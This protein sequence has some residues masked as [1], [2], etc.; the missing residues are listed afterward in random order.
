MAMTVGKPGGDSE[1]MMDINTTPLIDVMLVLLV[2]LIITLPVQTHAVKLDLP[3]GKPPENP[4]QPEVIDISI[5]FD[6]SIAWNGTPV[7]DR[8]TLENYF[9]NEQAKIPQPELHIRPDKLARYSF[10]AEVLAEAQRHNMIKI[11]LV[12][13]EQFM[14]Q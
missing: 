5:D 10:V 8:Q 6:G 11:G 9:D 7:P 12:G 14:P 3:Q 13:G 4:V 2:M 1:V